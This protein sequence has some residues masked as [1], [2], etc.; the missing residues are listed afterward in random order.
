MIDIIPYTP[1]WAWLA[2]L[3]ADRW[4]SALGEAV[5]SVHHIGSTAVPNL[6]ARPVIDLLVEM[7]PR[8]HP[9]SL[10]PAVEAMGYLWLGEHGQPHSRLCRRDATKNVQLPVQARI[11]ASGAREIRSHLAFRDALRADPL[12]AAGYESRKR[13]CASLHMDDA[14]AYDRC[15]S[16]WIETVEANALKE[17]RR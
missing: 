3:E 9:D 13:H 8:V 11:W 14:D 7:S 1:D 6:A 2:D 5:V 17:A 4:V 10:R 12:L 16:A 15:K